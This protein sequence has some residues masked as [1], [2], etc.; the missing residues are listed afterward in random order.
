TV[1]EG[2]V[3]CLL[4]PSGCGKTTA[5]RLAAGLE[6]LQRGRIGIAGRIV[7]DGSRNLPPEARDVGLMFQDYALF[8]HLRVLENVGFGLHR[9]PAVERERLAMEALERVGLSDYARTYPHTLSGGQQQ[10]VALARALAPGPSLLLL[11]EPFS[12]LDQQLRQEV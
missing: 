12:G 11:D 4:G 1:G 8:P 2:E 5:L 9:R 10:R 6:D 3:V 7:A